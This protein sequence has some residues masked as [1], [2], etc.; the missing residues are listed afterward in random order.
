MI[1]FPENTSA[2]AHLYGCVMEEIRITEYSGFI[3]IIY[4]EKHLSFQ[5]FFHRDRSVFIQ[6][7]NLQIFA[8]EHVST[9]ARKYAKHA[10]KETLPLWCVFCCNF[11]RKIKIGTDSCNS[12]CEKMPMLNK[13]NGEYYPD[14]PSVFF[15]FISQIKISNNS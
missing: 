15:L 12:S 14:S 10:V 6:T 5:F 3:G 13:S 1:F 8:R 2:I 7:G 11:D 4:N 9:L